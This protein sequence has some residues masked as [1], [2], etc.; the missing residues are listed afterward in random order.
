M[1]DLKHT[2]PVL[3]KQ[4][5]VHQSFITF[6][7]YRP[8]SRSLKQMQT[9]YM[10]RYMICEAISDKMRRVKKI[11]MNLLLI[12]KTEKATKIADE[13]WFFS[14]INLYKIFRNVK[15]LWKRQYFR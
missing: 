6:N 14:G 8:C 5:Y 11:R 2:N 15:K 13:C 7:P 10:K 9:W 1:T 3:S 12:M 4:L